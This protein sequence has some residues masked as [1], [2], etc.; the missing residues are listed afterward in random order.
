M[1]FKALVILALS[2]A[3]LQAQPCN[4]ATFPK[5]LGGTLGAT[6]AFALDHHPATDQLAVVGNTTDSG[7][8]GTSTQQA[9][10][11]LYRGG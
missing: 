10:V 4:R 1:E 3:L 8:T 7:L 5:V 9:I 6:Q 11:A 2:A